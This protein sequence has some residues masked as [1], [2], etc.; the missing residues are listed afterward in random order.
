MD[1]NVLA[2]RLEVWGSEIEFKAFKY[3]YIYIYGMYMVFICNS[4]PI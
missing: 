2:G 1:N 4:V 3:I